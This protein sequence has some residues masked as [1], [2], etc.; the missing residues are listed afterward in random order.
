MM[1]FKRPDTETLYSALVNKDPAYEGVAYVCVTSTK[2]FCR[3]TCTARKPKIENCRFRE[4]IAEC[5]EAGFRPCKRCKPMLSYGTADETVSSLL[6]ALENEPARRWRE[7]DVVALGHDPSTVR[8]S[9]KRRFGMSFLEIARLRRL[10]DAVTGLA[11]GEAVI[12]AQIDAGYESGSGFRAAINQ[13]FGASPAA[14]KGR[15]FLRGDWIDTPIGPMLAV[16][17]DHALHLLEFAD[18]PAL[19]AE[20]KRLKA[21][22][23][24]DMVLGRTA[25]TGQIAAELAAY[26]AGSSAIFETRLAGHGTP[27]ERGVWRN[28]REIP[29]GEI[30]S[31]SSLATTMERPSAVRA[32]ARA[33]GANQIAIVVPC[34]RVLGADGSLTGY[35][36][37]LWRKKW[38][39]EHERR[40]ASAQGKVQGLPL[41][42]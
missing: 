6:T 30:V 35:G 7:E 19:P 41:A 22:T 12:G 34:H 3:F 20:L 23:G 18:R 13:F 27:F 17:D 33:N 5:L 25:V 26:F 11:S 2:I 32:V 36:G 10:G 9:F 8:R 37:G 14:M 24:A 42:S 15:G 39:I 21:R 1:L 40:M 4:T 16:A 29:A 28:L 38:L 31:Y